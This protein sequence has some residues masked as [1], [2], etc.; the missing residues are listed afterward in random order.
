[1]SVNVSETTASRQDLVRIIAFFLDANEER[2]AERFVDVFQ[3]TMTF[4]ADFPELGASWESD[5]K[6][7]KNVRAKPIPGF[8]KYLIFYRVLQGTA[9]ILRIFHGHQDIDNLL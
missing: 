1:M 7:L 9:Y 3:E 4:I 2:V 8:E 5:E 6:R